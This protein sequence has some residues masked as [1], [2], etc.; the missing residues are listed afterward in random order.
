M[1]MQTPAQPSGFAKD[2]SLPTLKTAQQAVIGGKEDIKRFKDSLRQQCETSSSVFD[3][4][5]LSLA[6]DRL[7]APTV[8][9]LRIGKAAVMVSVS[10]NDI[11]KAAGHGTGLL[12]W[13]SP[14]LLCSLVGRSADCLAAKR[15]LSKFDEDSLERT[16][17]RLSAAQLS[18]RLADDAH[19][20]S[21]NSGMRPLAYNALVIGRDRNNVVST[22][23][24]PASTT[25]DGTDEPLPN[26][27]RRV[28]NIDIHC[29][30]KIDVS[31][32]FMRCQGAAVGR[33]SED[34]E[35]WMRTRGAYLAVQGIAALHDTNSSSNSNSSSGSS[36]MSPSIRDNVAADVA[37]GVEEAELQLCLR[38]AQSCLAE[39]FGRRLLVAEAMSQPLAMVTLSTGVV[40][41]Q[42][43]SA[44]DLG[45]DGDGD[46]GGDGDGREEAAESFLSEDD[47]DSTTMTTMTTPVA[48]NCS[49]VFATT[50]FADAATAGGGAPVSDSNNELG[51]WWQRRVRRRRTRWTNH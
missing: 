27:I 21:V 38:V 32:N 7:S 12:F 40:G 19:D 5:L 16:G 49:E 24:V 29:I 34:V 28:D 2:G 14:E 18:L 39:V 42:T 4:D 33:M 17:Q 10:Y 9:S 3:E 48:V 37:V 44:L 47:P 20:R 11:L 26:L 1:L 22:S 36:S 43:A 35:R 25:A 51:Q 30:F 41:A 31:G 8:Y 6:G 45:I 15:M 50:P 23:M 13:Q 46:G